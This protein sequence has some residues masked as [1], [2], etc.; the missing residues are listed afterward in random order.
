MCLSCSWDNDICLHRIKWYIWRHMIETTYCSTCIDTHNGHRFSYNIT[1][2][3]DTYFFSRKFYLIVFEYLHNSSR[4]TWRKTRRISYHDFSLVF[5]MK[6]IDILFG[7][8]ISYHTKCINVLRKGSCTIYQEILSSRLSF[9]ISDFRSSSEISLSN[10][11]SLKSIQI[12]SA[13]FFFWP[14]YLRLTAS[15][16]RSIAHKQGLSSSFSIFLERSSYISDAINFPSSI[17]HKSYKNRCVQN[18]LESLHCK[19]FLAWYTSLKY[20]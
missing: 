1:L 16:Q 13:N 4:S 12:F 20:F 14:I 17:M 7:I 3:Q 10:W 9:S 18:S 11:K 2:P 8:D 15:S 19:F 5:W 6:T